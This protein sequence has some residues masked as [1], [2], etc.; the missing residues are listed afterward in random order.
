MASRDVMTTEHSTTRRT[1]AV[2]LLTRIALNL[3]TRV[4]YPFLPAI[5]RG[6]GI[7]LETA[8]LLMTA[9]SAVAATSPLYGFLSDHYGRRALMLTG[10]VALVAGAAL[11]GVAPTLGLALVAF[12]LM[13]LS[14]ASYDPAM[15]AYV[16]DA[17]PYARRGR[18]FGLLEL[19]WAL[20]WLIGVPAAGFLIAAAGWRAP[21]WAIAGL[22]VIGLIATWR[23]CPTFN[24]PRQ[25]AVS[26]HHPW[27]LRR[28][29]WLSRATVMALAISM[30][31]VMAN[32]NVFIV[33]GAWMEDQF[34][35]AVSALG[36]ASIVISLA[37]LVA[38]S[39][40]AGLVDRLGKRR[41]VLGGLLLNVLAYLL[42]P[43]IAGTLAGALA[44]VTLTFLT[45]EFSIV[46]MIPLVSELAPETRGTVMALNVAGM[47]AG[48][49]ISSLIGP[50]V[51]A[52]GE[53]PLN[54]A[55]SA[56]FVLL[57][58]V[59]LWVGVRDTV[60]G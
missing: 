19:S 58:S 18:V 17:V 42:L 56:G 48:R 11:I 35:L 21:F 7:S 16:G 40:S 13:G 29:P 3:Q 57:A 44:G 46:S 14:K 52:V 22:G 43:R 41:A 2:I 23:C 27:K 31:L 47:A 6:L 60:T 39:S 33:Y 9:R 36:V 28:A 38:E 4:V 53:L 37:E 25:A 20:S 59:V 55:V 32:E 51:W 1:L 8:G 24:R 30:L 5:S 45:F 12:I 34:G 50:R 10:L 54:A 49:A 26:P 15:L